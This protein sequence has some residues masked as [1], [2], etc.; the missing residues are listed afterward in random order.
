MS[1][2][3]IP[4]T[5]DGAAD[6]GNTAGLEDLASEGRPSGDAIPHGDT[7]D[8][9]LGRSADGQ[10][11]RERDDAEKLLVRG[12][13]EAGAAKRG[14]DAE[15]AGRPRRK[16]KSTKRTP[17]RK[18]GGRGGEAKARKRRE[19]RGGRRDGNPDAE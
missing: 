19:G 8:A 18:R 4:G 12:D 10:A 2:R 3:I 5:R 1:T 16:R 6:A 14:T 15:D 9:E 7:D 17:R 13:A 11:V